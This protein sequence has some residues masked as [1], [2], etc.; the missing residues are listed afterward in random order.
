MAARIPPEGDTLQ[1]KH[2][3]WYAR[4]R[5]ER[6]TPNTSRGAYEIL[7]QLRVDAARPAIRTD[8][9][10]DVIILRGLPG[11][12]KTTWAKDFMRKH[13][14][15]Q[16][17]SRDDLRQMFRFG[18]YSPEQERFIREMQT[19]L[20][21][22]MLRDNPHLIVDN[23]NLKERDVRELK[24]HCVGWWNGAPSISVEILEFHTPLEECIRR[25]SLRAVPVGAERITEMYQRWQYECGAQNDEQRATMT[26]RID[27][28]RTPADWVDPDE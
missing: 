1:N 13:R 18:Y 2:G 26:A 17:I 23:T 15:Y 12:G 21:I 19:S 6:V 4:F 14:W 7:E 8:S 11:S 10:G 3:V 16:R 20:I 9:Q 28:L 5:G 25:D 27:A 24:R 22:D